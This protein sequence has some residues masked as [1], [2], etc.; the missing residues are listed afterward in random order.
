MCAANTMRA[1][2]AFVGRWDLVVALALCNTL[3]LWHPRLALVDV[4]FLAV[5]ASGR[6]R[7]ERLNWDHKKDEG[8]GWE[9]GM[10]RKKKKRKRGAT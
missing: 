9:S 4:A 8:G 7:W 3:R 5:R 6:S 10:A 2:A 1:S